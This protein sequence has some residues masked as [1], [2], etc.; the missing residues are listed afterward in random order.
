MVSQEH[1]IYGFSENRE[2]YPP[3][4][5]FTKQSVGVF[6]FILR[7]AQDKITLKRLVVSEVEPSR[8][9]V[10]SG[11]VEKFLKGIYDKTD[12]DTTQPNGL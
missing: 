8:R 3:L 10:L 4:F 6:Y 2:L 11:R 5:C 1:R 7:Q 9:V 12:S